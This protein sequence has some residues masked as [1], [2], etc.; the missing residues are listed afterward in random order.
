MDAWTRIVTV[1]ILLGSTGMAADAPA[2][3]PLPEVPKCPLSKDELPRLF[4]CGCSVPSASGTAS[5]RI[6]LSATFSGP[7]LKLISPKDLSGQPCGPAYPA[8]NYAVC[9]FGADAPLMGTWICDVP[10]RDG[11]N[12]R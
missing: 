4:H 11:E 6:P 1:A 9:D 2:R 12:D 3:L 5:G 10:A 8:T 7:L